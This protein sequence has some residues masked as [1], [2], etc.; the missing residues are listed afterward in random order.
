M[1]L[2]VLRS[3]AVDTYQENK[4]LI[5]C[6]GNGKVSP[7]LFVTLHLASSSV[8]TLVSIFVPLPA[9]RYHPSSL[10]K[11]PVLQ[12]TCSEWQLTFT[13]YIRQLQYTAE[14]TAL[15]S[16]MMGATQRL[17]FV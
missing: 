16:M 11:I 1:V 14:K 7:Q 3:H 2:L 12:T 10:A 8:P 5:E 17:G 4:S 15:K 6:N 9:L 13:T